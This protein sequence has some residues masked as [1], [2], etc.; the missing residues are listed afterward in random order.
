MGQPLKIVKNTAS[1]LIH[2]LSSHEIN[3]FDFLLE[4]LTSDHISCSNV[5][6]L[7]FYSFWRAIFVT[8]LPF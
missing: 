1:P 6:L 8:C 2:R 3:H 5:Y 4:T 7:I